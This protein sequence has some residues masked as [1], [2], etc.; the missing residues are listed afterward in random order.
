MV[1]VQRQPDPA[2]GINEAST[3]TESH[4][5]YLDSLVIQLRLR[6][7]S[8]RDIGSIVEEA[9]HHLE[10]S[11]E[12]PLEAFGPVDTY[13]AAIAAARG[14]NQ[15]IAGW[16]R[17]EFALAAVHF[18]SWF[19]LVQGVVAWVGGEPMQLTFGQVLGILGGLA[20]AAW[21]IW[22]LLVRYATG[23]SKAW[24]PVV[25]SVVSVG[26]VVGIIEIAE[27]WLIRAD[28]IAELSPPW[29]VA[30]SAASLAVSLLMLIKSA[31][32]VQPPT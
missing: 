5:E 1:R 12:S 11:G 15:A 29:V 10:V 7:V 25:A 3:M 19:F 2:A 24:V 22:P 32:P 21:V 6:D 18:V 30:V 26:V 13:A 20:L 23:R 16:N 28:V 4:Q 17:R 31:D 27:R 9:R 14:G 8:G